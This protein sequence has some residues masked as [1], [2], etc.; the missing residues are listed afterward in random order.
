MY[1]LQFGEVID[2]ILYH[3]IYDFICLFSPQSIALKLLEEVN[4]NSCWFFLFSLCCWLFYVTKYSWTWIHGFLTFLRDT[5]LGSVSVYLQRHLSGRNHYW[6]CDNNLL[7]VGMVFY[8]TV[9]PF[10]KDHQ[11]WKDQKVF[12][13][14]RLS[15]F[16]DK[17]VLYIYLYSHVV[18]NDR[19]QC[20]WFN[21]E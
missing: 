17:F 4:R 8:Y 10:L 5:S 3:I 14:A 2:N 1:C 11:S 7:D 19:F 9:K 12:I 13:K 16:T 18:F 6:E 20:I 21:R 15:I